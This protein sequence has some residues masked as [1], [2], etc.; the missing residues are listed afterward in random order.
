MLEFIKIY[1][2]IH[3]DVIINILF[4]SLTVVFV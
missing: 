2:Y 3:F 4:I 1:M